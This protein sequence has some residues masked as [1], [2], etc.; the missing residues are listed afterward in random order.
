MSVIVRLRTKAVVRVNERLRASE[1]S[2][3][4]IGK[5]SFPASDQGGNQSAGMPIH[6]ST[7][8][9]IGDDA[10]LSAGEVVP[11][12]T[13]TT[14]LLVKKPA[15]SKPDQWYAR[16]RR[17]AFIRIDL[18]GV[19]DSEIVDATLQIHGVATNIG[20]ASMMPDATFAVYGLVDESQDD[21]DSKTISWLDCPANAGD[22][23]EV[24]EAATVLV[25]NFVVPQ[26]NPEGRFEVSGR[27]L[28][29]FLQ[30]DTN[31]RVTFILIPETV[32][33]EGES[34]VHGFASKRHPYLAAPT[35]R[36]RVR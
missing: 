16:W 32:G 31:G 23:I 28:L 8:S 7:A 34:Y 36:M 27:S 5:G 3:L 4:E 18:S 19:N 20:F 29:K 30:S 26:S 2:M 9:G 21:W 11:A 15:S 25:G 35:L 24:D 13:S 22:A 1:D 17:K 14:A 33:E 10:Y 6:I 12:N